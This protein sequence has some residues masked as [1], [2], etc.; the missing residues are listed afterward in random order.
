[1]TSALELEH[2]PAIAISLRVPRDPKTIANKLI[3][4]DDKE[5]NTPDSKR[6][7]ST[8][9]CIACDADHENL[10]IVEYLLEAQVRT[11]EAK[12]PCMDIA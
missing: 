10:P 8:A 1:M 3:D 5:P 9:L 7:G 12:G 2:N 6:S 11:C 4:Q